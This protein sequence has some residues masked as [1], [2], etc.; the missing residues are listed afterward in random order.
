MTANTAQITDIDWADMTAVGIDID[1]VHRQTM[2]DIRGQEYVA[3]TATVKVAFGPS[4]DTRG[5]DED[6]SD[7]LGWDVQ[8][9]ERDGEEWEEVSHEHT[10]DRAQVLRIVSAALA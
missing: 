2:H 4:V 1:C 7:D 5:D 8:L 6:E 3:T 9:Y 10:H